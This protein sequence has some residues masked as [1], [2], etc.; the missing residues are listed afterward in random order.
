MNKR[1][2]LT[3]VLIGTAGAVLFAAPRTGNRS[4]DGRV[5][6]EDFPLQ[7]LS[8]AET[9]G[10]LLM[11][12]EEKLA[13]DVYNA[14]AQK[15]DVPVFG[16]IAASEKTHTEKIA[17]LLARYDLADPV[18]TDSVP[19]VYS[20]TE[21]TELYSALV[22]RGSESLEEALKVGADVE[23][24]DIKDLKELMAETDNEDISHVYSNLL[25]GSER[26]LK[27]FT[28]NVEQDRGRSRGR[29]RRQS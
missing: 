11:R 3:M 14:L 10:L 22:S 12:E 28:R 29:G 6:L 15:W 8:Q 20:N 18:R 24:L 19:G 13:M 9:E 2:V 7:E 21:L 23:R 27:A 25:A 5:S 26:H 1:I 4:G 16:N 17:E